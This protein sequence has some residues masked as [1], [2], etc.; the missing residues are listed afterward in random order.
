MQGNVSH[1]YSRMDR[2]H[3]EYRLNLVGVLIA[4]KFCRLVTW[5]SRS[6]GGTSNFHFISGRGYNPDG[7]GTDYGRPPVGPGAKPR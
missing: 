5:R 2:I 1:Q 4:D 7:L 6:S 3:H